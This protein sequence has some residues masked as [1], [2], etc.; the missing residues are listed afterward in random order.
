M[1]RFALCEPGFFCAYRAEQ[2]AIRFLFAEK[3]RILM[4]KVGFE[5]LATAPTK[6]GDFPMIAA[7][8]ACNH[9]SG[10]RRFDTSKRQCGTW[11]RIGWHRIANDP[12]SL[13][14]RERP[15]GDR[16]PFQL[17]INAETIRGKLPLEVA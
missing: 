16:R 3:L 4:R 17:V 9:I 12:V 13:D 11:K 10:R 7:N 6:P 5:I 2:Q 14:K 15:V 8:Y 1:A